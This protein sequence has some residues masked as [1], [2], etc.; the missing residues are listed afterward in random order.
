MDVLELEDFESLEDLKQDDTTGRVYDDSEFR[1]MMSCRLT[2]PCVILKGMT[3]ETEFEFFKKRP[4]R[5]GAVVLPLFVEV[6]GVIV[7]CSQ[8]EF[9]LESM[10]TVKAI[11][12]YTVVLCRAED[13]SVVLNLEDPETFI[14]LIKV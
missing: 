12:N 2:Y 5:E 13:D 6:S 1:D 8:L 4:V 7:E 3:T 9:S 14:K 11:N 10:L